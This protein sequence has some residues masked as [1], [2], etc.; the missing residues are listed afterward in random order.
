[1]RARR[2]QARLCGRDARDPRD[3][4]CKRGQ[5]RP[6]RAYAGLRSD[7]TLQ[8]GGQ[9]LARICCASGADDTPLQTGGN[10][11]APLCR[12]YLAAYPLQAGGGSPLP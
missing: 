6:S 9:P 7:T 5:P 3:T 1:M 10:L 12:A 11:F 4:P 8:A 2:A